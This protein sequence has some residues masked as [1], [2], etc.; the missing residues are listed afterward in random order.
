MTATPLELSR[1]INEAW[2]DGRAAET[3]PGLFTEDAVIVGPGLERLAEGRDACV[4]TYVAFVETTELVEFE[5][6][7][8][9]VDSFGPAAVVDYAYKAV[10]RRDGEERTDYGRDVILAV[11]TD[12]GWRA[13]W[14]MARPDL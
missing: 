10:Y 13:A 11:E 14:R 4:E 12:S 7:D 5:E 6:F 1:A 9:R 3:L 8:H 2:V